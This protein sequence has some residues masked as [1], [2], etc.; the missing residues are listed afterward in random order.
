MVLLAGWL[1]GSRWGSRPQRSCCLHEQHLQ[2]QTVPAAL[3]QRNCPFLTLTLPLF[4]PRPLQA[5][6]CYQAALERNKD[7][8]QLV[9]KVRLLQ[10]VV[11]SRG[12]QRG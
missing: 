3:R 4:P 7:S 11:K 9:E 1:G 12:Q 2:L 5:L 6:P 10:K 8:K